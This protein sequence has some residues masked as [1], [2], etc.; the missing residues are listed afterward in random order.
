MEVVTNLC[1]F[2]ID[3]AQECGVDG[4]A[5]IFHGGEPLMLRK[6]FFVEMCS[7]ITEAVKNVKLRFSV[8]TNGVL[9]DE[10][11]LELLKKHS[12]GL[13]IS[14]DGP[15][16]IHNKNRIY[17][18]GRGSYMDVREAIR[19]ARSK[20]VVFGTLSV[21]DPQNDPKEIY[22][23]LRELGVEGMDFLL[24]D[25]CYINPPPRPVREYGE[26][27]C[28]I[29]D[30]WT[31]EDNPEID[32]RILSSIL[33]VI[34]GGR[35]GLQGIG[36]QV[37][38]EPLTVF[39]NGDL[40]PAD[41]YCVIGDEV[42]YTGCNVSNSSLKLLLES[43][44]FKQINVAKKCFPSECE[45]CRWK[46]VCGA[47]GLQNRYS[48]ENGFLNKSIYCEALSMLYSHVEKFLIKQGVSSERI[49]KNLQ[50]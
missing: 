28:A 44:S 8:Q 30:E 18:D 19:L 29:F 42:M 49:E 13:G 5:V 46:K 31:K 16:R 11:W 17:K 41:D 15:E 40:S 10:E 24:P 37:R 14:L 22:T 20:D 34:L 21:I 26:F 4:Y 43:P 50:N 23:H 2:L 3:G 47:G 6:T 27:L 39:S 48:K 32:V 38:M 7:H 36:P 33:K 35:S 1:R 12:I 9:L 45:I 25:C